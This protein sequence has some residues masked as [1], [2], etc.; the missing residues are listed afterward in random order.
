MGN[1]EGSDAAVLLL[2]HCG[3]GPAV[4]RGD[5]LAAWP[6]PQKQCPVGSIPLRLRSFACLTRPNCA[7]ARF[8]RETSQRCVRPLAFRPHGG[9]LAQDQRSDGQGSHCS[10]RTDRRA[11]P[12]RLSL[13]DAD[14]QRELGRSGHREDGRIAIGWPIHPKTACFLTH[15]H[16][17]VSHSSAMR[18]LRL[19]TN[20]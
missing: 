17:R 12:A 9:L 7:P 1:D 15:C 11:R 20:A 8:G 13:T 18:R 3:L 19:R 16:S 5:E 6:H 14:E 4:M 10:C 2:D